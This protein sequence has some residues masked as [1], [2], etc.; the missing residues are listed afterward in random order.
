MVRFTLKILV[1]LLF[2]VCFSSVRNVEAVL[3]A[4]SIQCMGCH[5]AAIASDVTLSVCP[6]MDCD[7]PVG[8]DY[9]L[10]A[11]NNNGLKAPVSLDPSLKLIGNNIVGCGTCHVPYAAPT[12]TVFSNLRRLYPTIADPML[13]MD[14]RRSELCL[15]CHV[16]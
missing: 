11:S 8:V 9:T 13:V 2:L 7:H 3:D 16:K 14:N 10:S 5:D 15:G 12:H 6:T 1:F 4:E